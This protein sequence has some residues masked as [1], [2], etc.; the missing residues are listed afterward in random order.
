MLILALAV[1]LGS[2]CEASRSTTDCQR[3]QDF[4][5]NCFPLCQL[6]YNNIIDSQDAQQCAQ[7]VKDAYSYW[8][9]CDG[10]CTA[11]CQYGWGSCAFSHYQQVGESPA[12][13][14]GAAKDAG[15]D[16]G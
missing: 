11:N 12:H 9:R 1:A 5:C 8:K 16:G 3:L 14:C 13:V 6:Q 4:S 2:G 10:T 7:A 15:G